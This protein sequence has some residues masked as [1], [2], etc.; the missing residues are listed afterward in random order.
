MAEEKQ[1]NFVMKKDVED[2]QNGNKG[3]K[4]IAIQFDDILNYTEY[5]DKMFVETKSVDHVITND[6]DR[7]N[8]V[9]WYEENNKK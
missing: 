3:K 9:K 2:S 4:S 8:F 1:K 7:K 5:P 6:E